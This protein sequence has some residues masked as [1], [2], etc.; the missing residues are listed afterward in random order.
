MVLFCLLDEMNGPTASA[1]MSD[2]LD[3]ANDSW[4][5]HWMLFI[6]LLSPRQRINGIK[7]QKFIKNRPFRREQFQFANGVEK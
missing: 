3:T 6:L 1:S 2:N 4:I 7:T 5:N